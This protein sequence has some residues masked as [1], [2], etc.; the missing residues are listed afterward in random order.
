[1]ATELRPIPNDKL[2]VGRA[3]VMMAAVGG[4]A[5]DDFGD[6]E[7]FTM[8]INVEEIQRYGKNSGVKR[9]RRSDVIQVDAEITIEALDMTPA[10]RALSVGA[11]LSTMYVQTAETTA[12]HDISGVQAGK[13]F[14]LPKRKLSKVTV[15]DGAGGVTY[16]SG[17]DYVLLEESGYLQIIQIPS[18]ADADIEVTY[19]AAEIVVSEGKFKAGIGSNMNVRRT[20]HVISINTSGPRDQLVLHDVQVRPS[21]EK[22]MIGGDEFGS[23]SLIGKVFVDPSQ[24]PEFGLGYLTEIAP[25]GV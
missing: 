24:P 18:G 21:G 8:S 19:D 25:A 7:S 23:I 10:L 12:K 22:A 3:N 20:I 4:T 9:L 11:E 13:I 14:E 1:M 5:F 16:A 15:T 2:E 17:V 6:C